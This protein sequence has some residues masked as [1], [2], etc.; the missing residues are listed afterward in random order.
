MAWQLLR[1][2]FHTHVNKELQMVLIFLAARNHKANCE[3]GTVS[4]GNTSRRVEDDRKANLKTIQRW[5]RPVWK[6]QPDDAGIRGLV[7]KSYRL[8]PTPLSLL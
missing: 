2:C 8:W 5:R 3:V 4:T 7:H 1:R 6:H